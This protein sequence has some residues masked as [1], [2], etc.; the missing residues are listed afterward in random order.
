MSVQQI[1]YPVDIS[2]P[3][4]LATSVLAQGDLEEDNHN[5][6]DG[7]YVYAQNHRHLS[8][9]LIELLPLLNVSCVLNRVQ[10]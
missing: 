4:T 8:S 10:Q 9:T 5:G 6:R 2:Q 1:T 3:L 7:G